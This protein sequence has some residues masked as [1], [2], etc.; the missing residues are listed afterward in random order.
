MYE[1]NAIVYWNIGNPA[2]T[3]CNL[4]MVVTALTCK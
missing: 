3:R 2:A 1:E 4:L